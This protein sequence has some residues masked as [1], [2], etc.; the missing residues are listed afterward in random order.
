MATGSCGGVRPGIGNTRL[1]RLRRPPPPRGC[2]ARVPGLRTGGTIDVVPR[3][4]GSAPAGAE[5]SVKAE[6][7]DPPQYRSQIPKRGTT[8]L[9]V[10]YIT[11]KRASRHEECMELKFD[12]FVA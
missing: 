2:P 12:I 8:P 10:Y 5:C 11:R 4:G 7:P 3:Q 9:H 6:D 1:P